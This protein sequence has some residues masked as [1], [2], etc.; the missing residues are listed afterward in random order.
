MSNVVLRKVCL[1]ILKVPHND[2]RYSQLF[3]FKLVHLVR[4]VHGGKRESWFLNIKLT[5]VP[6]EGG[7]LK[8]LR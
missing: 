7:T 4:N 5:N 3:S 8:V 2:H 6:E 1:E